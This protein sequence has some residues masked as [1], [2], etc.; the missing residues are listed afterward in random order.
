MA[1]HFKRCSD[2]CVTGYIKQ[3][4]LR[5]TRNRGIKRESG[6]LEG[7]DSPPEPTSFLGCEP[8][9]RVGFT[10][11]L[12]KRKQKTTFYRDPG[13]NVNVNVNHDFQF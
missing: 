8:A 6:I 1:E 12:V 2:M 9:V 11:I 13:V 4:Q 3:Y 10:E 7:H 5:Y